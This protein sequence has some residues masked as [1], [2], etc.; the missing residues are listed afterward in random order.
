M[1]SD[2]QPKVVNILPALYLM[3]IIHVHTDA[4][5]KTFIVAN[6]IVLKMSLFLYFMA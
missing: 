2:F 1:P 4:K 3:N 6:I 5:L